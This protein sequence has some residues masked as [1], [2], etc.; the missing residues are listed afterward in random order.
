M[1]D[2][3]TKDR[4][5][6]LEAKYQ[7]YFALVSVAITFALTIC[8]LIFD[9]DVYAPVAGTAI[10]AIFT[11]IRIASHTQAILETQKVEPK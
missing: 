3:P 9:S 5:S 4:A 1:P 6:A 8:N 10:G 7:I 2:N 11:Y